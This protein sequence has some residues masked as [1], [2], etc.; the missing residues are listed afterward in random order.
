MTLSEIKQEAGHFETAMADNVALTLIVGLAVVLA[1]LFL[2]G[3][4]LDAFLSWKKERDKVKAVERLRKH[5]D[6]LPGIKS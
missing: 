6:S 3:L 5:L 4:M 2:G 1:A